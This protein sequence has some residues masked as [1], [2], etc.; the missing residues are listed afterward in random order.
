MLDALDVTLMLF[1]MQARE[2]PCADLKRGLVSEEASRALIGRSRRNS[3]NA[4]ARGLDDQ[5]QARPCFALVHLFY[6]GSSVTVSVLCP[7]L[8]RSRLGLNDLLRSLFQ[9][10]RLSLFDITS[11]S[12]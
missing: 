12:C 8:C 2:R 5:P 1:E 6:T 3:L 10:D 9:D 7:W 4:I 11:G